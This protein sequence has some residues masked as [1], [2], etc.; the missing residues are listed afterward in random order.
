MNRTEEI[1]IILAEV[2]PL[3]LISCGAPEDEYFIE[4]SSLAEIEKTTQISPQHIAE[5]FY[6]W[7]GDQSPFLNN[8]NK[9]KLSEILNKIN[10]K[11]FNRKPNL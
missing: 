3:G 8:A 4:A 2:D 9:E 7:F 5:V 10:S 11:N 1:N 6:N